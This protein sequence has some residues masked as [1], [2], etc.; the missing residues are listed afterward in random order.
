MAVDLI[1]AASEIKWV[2]L[3]K[4][5]FAVFRWLNIFI[6][7]VAIIN[8]HLTYLKYE[9]EYIFISITI[10]SLRNNISAIDRSYKRDFHKFELLRKLLRY[11]YF[12]SI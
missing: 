6:S 11:W 8:Q 7:Y 10:I 2:C 4:V 9:S 12:N 3:R 5:I 1:A